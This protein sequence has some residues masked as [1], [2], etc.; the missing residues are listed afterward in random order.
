MYVLSRNNLRVQTCLKCTKKRPTILQS[1]LT[2]KNK[3][4]FQAPRQKTE[5]RSYKKEL[6]LKFIT[7]HS[8]QKSQV[9]ENSGATYFFFF[10]LRED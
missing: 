9:P 5:I 6:F 2:Y 7:H 10:N 1:I 8:C 4:I 3:N